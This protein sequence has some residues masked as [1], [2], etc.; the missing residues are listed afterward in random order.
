MIHTHT[1]MDFMSSSLLKTQAKRSL[2]LHSLEQ[3][4][5]PLQLS[6]IGIIPFLLRTIIL[7]TDVFKC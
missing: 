7:K 5:I 6:N 4:K 3:T 2:M 1:Y